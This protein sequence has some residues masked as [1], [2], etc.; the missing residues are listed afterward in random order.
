[1]IKASGEIDEKSIVHG[2]A[3]RVLPIQPLARASEFYVPNGNH[4]RIALTTIVTP[5][6]E[7]GPIEN[8]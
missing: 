2:Q 5:I 6:S 4:D 3:K 1:M 8:W 7:Y